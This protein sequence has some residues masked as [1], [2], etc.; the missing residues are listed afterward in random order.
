LEALS[1]QLDKLQKSQFKNV[2]YSAG[3]EQFPVFAWI[4]LIF[5]VLDIF[6]LDRRNNWLSKINFFSKK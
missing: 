5:L 4:A 3:A 1:T 6:V 2:K